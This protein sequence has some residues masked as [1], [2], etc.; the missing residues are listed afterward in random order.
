MLERNQSNYILLSIVQGRVDLN[1]AVSGYINSG[2]TVANTSVPLCANISETS[3]PSTITV[4]R[5]KKSH[6]DEHKQDK[7]FFRCVGSFAA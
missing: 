7:Y 5:G 1:A 3:S 2:S 6:F 4:G